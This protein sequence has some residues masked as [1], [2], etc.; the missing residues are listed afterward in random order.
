MSYCHG[1]VKISLTDNII[2]ATFIGSFNYEGAVEYSRRIKSIVS[3]LEERPFVMIIDNTELEGGTPEGFEE[4]EAFNSWLNQTQ[5]KAKAFIMT[6]GVQKR[7]IESRTPS[8]S[9]QNTCFFSNY[10]EA[11]EW[12]KNFY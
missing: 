12:L 5:L 3:S 6:S 11:N 2:T 1:E 9:L 8:L 7:I 4:L 10:Q